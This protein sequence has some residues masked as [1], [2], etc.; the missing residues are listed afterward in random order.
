MFTY[1][2]INIELLTLREPPVLLCVFTFWVPCCDV[3]YDFCI[4]MMLSSSLSPVVC[5]RVH[6]VFTLFACV[7]VQWCKSHIV[8]FCLFRLMYPMLPVSLDC[9]FLISPSVFS[10]VYC[11][12]ILYICISTT[13]LLNLF[14]FRC[15]RKTDELKKKAIQT[16]I[17]KER[18]KLG[19][20]T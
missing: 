14:H 5:R 3:R 12:T 10:Y 15:C 1:T 7:C 11:T 4:T 2:C 6:I 8:L 18:K 16:A 20:I 9:P 19:K 13:Y 17:K